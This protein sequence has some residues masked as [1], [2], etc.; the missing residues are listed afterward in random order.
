M[1]EPTE[2]ESR[3]TLDEFVRTLLKVN[4]E[5]LTEPELLRQAP[6][7]TPVGRLDEATAARQP[8]L[9]WTPAS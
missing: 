5:A 3:G 4:Q 1:I 6:V 9:R 7:S 8:N 2:S